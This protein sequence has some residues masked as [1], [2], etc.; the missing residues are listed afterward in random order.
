[1]STIDSL[2]LALFHRLRQGGVPLGVGEYLLAVRTLRAGYG[3]DRPEHL[4]SIC[5]LLW[6]KSCEDQELFD[7]TYAELVEPRLRPR[8]TTSPPRSA[9][10]TGP[11]PPTGGSP[12]A[13]PTGGTVEDP[14]GLPAS[15]QPAIVPLHTFVP[16]S[17]TAPLGSSGFYQL[18]PRPPISRREMATLWKHLRLLRREGPQV[19]LDAEATIDAIGR[20]GVFSQPA[21]RPARRNQLRLLLLI[22]RRGSMVPFQPL[23]EALVESIHRGGMLGHTVCFYFHNVPGDHLAAHPALADRR[24]ATDVLAAHAKGQAVLIVSDAGAARGCYSEA[25]VVATHT[26]LETLAPFTHRVAWL[27]PLPVARWGSTSAEEIEQF[28]PMFSLDRKGLIATIE[29]LR[30]RPLIAGKKS[31]YVRH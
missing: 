19:E 12:P 27:N 7:L 24:P 13:P 1:M 30:G 25:R 8:P 20:T 28:V 21:L 4:R 22:D 29:A 2:L 11:T 3:L 10:P 5:R 31:P 15:P 17:S 9:P 6:A 26:F 18:M 23:V 16:E 14:A